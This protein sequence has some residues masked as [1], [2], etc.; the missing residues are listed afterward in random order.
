M[1]SKVKGSSTRQVVRGLGFTWSFRGRHKWRSKSPH[2]GD[3]HSYYP[4]TL[5][6]GLAKRDSP[7][8]FCFGAIREVKLFDFQPTGA[9]QSCCKEEVSDNGSFFFWGGV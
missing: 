9:T 6:V 8:A 2:M 5:Q 4:W 1:N 3:K 7:V